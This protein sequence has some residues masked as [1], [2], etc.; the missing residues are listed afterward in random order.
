MTSMSPSGSPRPWL[1]WSPEGLEGM[2][3]PAGLLLPGGVPTGVAVLQ[4][5]IPAGTFSTRSFPGSGAGSTGAAGASAPLP[6]W[7]WGPRSCT[8]P[9]G[10]PGAAQA[11][12]DPQPPGPSRA[13]PGRAAAPKP[14]VEVSAAGR[15]G[16]VQCAAETWGSTK[17]SPGALCS[18]VGGSGSSAEPLAMS[19]QMGFTE[20]TPARRGQGR[21]AGLAEPLCR[22]R[23]GQGVGSRSTRP[24]GCCRCGRC[25][26]ARADRGARPAGGACGA[27]G[28]P[29]VQEIHEAGK[30]CSWLGS[31]HRLAEPERETGA[32]AAVTSALAPSS[33]RGCRVGSHLECRSLW[34]AQSLEG[35]EAPAGP[36]GRAVGA[37]VVA[38]PWSV[39]TGGCC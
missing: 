24:W 36:G 2:S 3:L 14:S 1:S 5:S 9:W 16:L 34:G 27:G 10:V 37:A 35:A 6:R 23:R 22:I 15:L 28:A 13:A 7:L 30:G 8:G 4:K 29:A 38:A 25:W 20:H 32:M 39:P 17:P 19:L 31:W 26:G 33:V 12:R 18:P 21:S 11:G